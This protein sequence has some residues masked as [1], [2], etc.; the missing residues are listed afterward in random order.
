MKNEEIEA[1]LPEFKSPNVR[2]R[3]RT[4]SPRAMWAE[5]LIGNGED[6]NGNP[7]WE[8]YSPSALG[9][10]EDLNDIIAD[11]QIVR[12]WILN[13][14]PEPPCTIDLVKGWEVQWFENGAIAVSPVEYIRVQW[15]HP[16]G[17]LI[18]GR[19]HP[20]PERPTDQ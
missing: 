5:V 7:E 10:V 8:A 11:L 2:W 6:W 4:R 14:P 17:V 9:A 12:D 20:W 19:L 16:E 18:A 15:A 13:I 1:D 3:H